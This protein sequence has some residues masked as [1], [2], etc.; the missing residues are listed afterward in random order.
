YED[1]VG[2]LHILEHGGNMAGLSSLMVLIPTERA[3]FF[4]VN[5]FEGSRL[6]DDLKWLLLERFFPAARQRRPVPTTLPSIAEVQ[7]ERFAGDY[8]PLTS[9]FSCQPV[10]AQSVMTVTANQDGTLGF[11]GG[12]W[13]AVD[14]LRFVK[15]N[16]S[17]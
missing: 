17:G 5:H 7:P 14:S 13:I 4:V 16:G 15:D 2:D 9:C 8:I 3:A 10:R 12:R 11:A 6:R 1:Y